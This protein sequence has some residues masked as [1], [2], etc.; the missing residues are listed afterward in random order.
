MP[1]KI[2][3][4]L[5]HSDRLNDFERRRDLFFARATADVEKIGR[6]AAI[7]L[8]DIHRGHRQAGIH[9]AGDAAIELDVIEIDLLASISAGPPQ[10]D[11]ASLD[12]LVSIKRVVI[13]S[14]LASTAITDSFRPGFDNARIDLDQRRVA[15]HR[16]C[17]R[18]ATARLRID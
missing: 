18:R 13:Q 15:F 4:G 9:Q 5:L 12:V 1:P 17:K 6:A 14:I 3:T 10:P 2:F 7:M 8:D 16:S 11:R